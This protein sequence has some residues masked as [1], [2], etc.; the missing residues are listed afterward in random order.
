[1]THLHTTKLIDDQELRKVLGA[2]SLHIV[3]SKKPSKQCQKSCTTSK[4]P[5]VIQVIDKVVSFH[6]ILIEPSKFAFCTI[7]KGS[8]R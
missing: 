6:S 2:L 3:L 7:Q 8:L 1:M 5:T 4:M